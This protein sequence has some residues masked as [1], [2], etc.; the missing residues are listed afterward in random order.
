[1]NFSKEIYIGPARSIEDEGST[2]VFDFGS[3]GV[4]RGFAIR[5]GG[6][7]YAYRN[8]CPHMGLELDWVEGDFFDH[9]GQ[10][11]ICSNHGALF[12]PASGKCIHGPCVGQTLKPLNIR[13]MDD[14]VWVT[15]YPHN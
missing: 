9:S 2:L 4:E 6:R 7:I 10:Y 8:W 13:I 15:T 5:I 3:G 11:V 12:D 14:G 1:M